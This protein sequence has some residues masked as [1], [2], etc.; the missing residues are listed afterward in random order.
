MDTLTLRGVRK[1]FGGIHALKGV[2][3][4]LR[5]GEI[6]ALVGENG[7][8]KS[9]L[10]KIAGGV[11]PPDEGRIEID[12]KPVSFASPRD[13]QQDGIVVIHQTPLLCPHLSVTENILLGHL[14]T[15]WGI[16]QW[17]QAAKRSA[18]LL[19]QLNASLPLDAP[20]GTLSVAQQQLVAL[21]RALSLQARWLILDEPTAS[22]S[23]TE[24]ERLFAI[25]RQ[26]KEQGVGIL[27][28]SHRL[29]EVLEL[30]D[31][32]TVLRD[33]EKVA[34]L[35]AR[36]ATREQL[37]ALMVG[38]PVA[39]DKGGRM[40]DEGETEKRRNGERQSETLLR[41]HS[42]SVNGIV[43]G[44]SLTVRQGE[45]VGLFGLVGSGRSEL[46]Q[47]IVGL[48]EIVG[49][50]VEWQGKL[51]R[52]RSPNDALRHGIAYLPE[53]RLHQSLLLPRSIRENI[54]LPNLLR[55]SRRGVVNERAE[56]EAAEQQTQ[57]LRV[58]MTT[59]EQPV[60][61]LS[62]GNQQ[63]VALA[64]WLLTNPQLFIL[65]E[66]THGVDVATK[67]EIHRLITQWR[68]KGKTILLI[69]SELEE[70]QRLCDRIVVMRQGHIVGEFPPTAAPAEILAAAFGQQK[71]GR[72]GD[73]GR[74][75]R[76]EEQGETEKRGSGETE[77]GER[78]VPHALFRL[79][80]EVSL[81]LFILTL[82][83]FVGWRNPAFL[84]GEHWLTLLQE[85][86]PT[87]IGAIAIAMVILS[88]NLDLSVGSLL[89]ACA[90]TAGHA[91]K[92]EWALP[93]VI[94]LA[95]SLGAAVGAVNGFLVTRLLLPSIIVTLGMMGIIRGT[96][97]VLTK[98]YWVIGLPES[99][100]WLGVG[101]IAGVPV[102]VW[103]ALF[104]LAL[105]WFISRY[106]CWGRDLYAIGSNAEA[107]RLAGILVPRRVFSIFVFC[108]ALVGLAALVYT[109]RFPVVQSETGKG[110]ELDVIT[111]AVFGGVN[112]FGGAGSVVGAA[113][114]AF[115]VTVLHSALTFLQL[116]GEW[117]KFALG[118]L[119]L[120][121]VTIDALRQRR[122]S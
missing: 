121:S 116:A 7:A 96:M 120:L 56:R 95:L 104:V 23:R 64:K 19:Q 68:Q 45:I 92:A 24:V 1:T 118:G 41:L 111:A 73:K 53:D 61:Q 11:F 70:L 12:G 37:I 39:W 112:I 40:G 6:H 75:M 119:I 33:G 117:D 91:A 4:E 113:L 107:A 36:T 29:E 38:S 65:D 32:I 52:F 57:T 60:Q 59:V 46:A 100:R 2:D 49:G 110:F 67:A 87:L 82:A 34:T 86:A 30:S 89:G 27:F 115:A 109:A 72:A 76:D 101:K 62:G 47:A 97:L 93:L 51:V 22:L 71:T 88:G 66:P 77:M 114:G 98:G 26:L 3:L 28:V 69:S 90:M 74:R 10:I 85:S 83:L 42:V 84:T 48:R 14:P 80:R 58:R 79:S 108:S 17:G 44:V 18:E 5:S 55:F 8:G 15:R 105:C 31:R 16:V 13:A 122:R 20:V 25:L 94:L 103:I 21:A 9:T 35:P 63:K 43:R 102:P 50:S 99:F 81:L 78:W 106:T 54:G